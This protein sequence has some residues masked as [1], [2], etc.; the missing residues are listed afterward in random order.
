MG[1]KHDFKA[2]LTGV[3]G[4]RDE[5]RPHLR[6]AERDKFFS[7]FPTA[8]QCFP[9]FGARVR[10]L[11]C[12]HRQFRVVGEGELRRMN[13]GL[14]LHPGD[15]LVRSARVHYDTK[16]VFGHEIGDQIVYHAAIFQQHGG[17]KRFAG[18]RQ[19]VHIVRQQVAQEVAN[20]C[21]F[22]IHHAHM[23]DIEHAAIV[24]YLVVF[25]YLR[26]VVHWH[27][28]A[29]KVHHFRA[30]RAVRR[31]QG[32]LFK[33]RHGRFPKIK[34]AQHEFA[35]RPICPRYLRDCNLR[36]VPLRWQV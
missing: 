15:V 10:A 20:P 23:R 8:G 26:T 28:P 21:A 24:A 25:I 32:G 33:N 2:V 29:A 27:V 16:P 35:L 12:D 14:F 22:H 6:R 13:F 30:Q 1:G 17:I 11:H 7:Q 34:K 19:L 9:D 18:Q 3:A 31:I 4:A 36:C 5:H